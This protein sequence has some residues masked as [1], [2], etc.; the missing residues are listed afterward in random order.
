MH[1]SITIHNE[2]LPILIR[3]RRGAHRIVVRYRPLQHAISLTLPPYVGI[4]QGLHFAH[5]KR[6]WI[7]RQIAAKP[8]H[9]PFSDGQIIPLLGKHYTLCHK[10]GRGVVSIDGDRI[11]VP[12]DVQFMARRLR[13]WLK[14]R[15]RAEI[16]ALAQI[17]AQRV[18]RRIKKISLRDTSSRW[19]S[20]SHNGNLSFS[21]RLAFAPWEVLD[22]LVSHEVAHLKEH[23]HSEAF[24]ALVAELCPHYEQ[25]GRWLKAHGAGLYAYG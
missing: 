18:G 5:E 19:G 8:E 21:W 24:W 13:E 7:E 11:L 20:C 25:A 1:Y 14:A 17:K 15:A 9:I 3:K 2:T 6:D 22:Y 4:R 10:G 12:G 23:N 16:M